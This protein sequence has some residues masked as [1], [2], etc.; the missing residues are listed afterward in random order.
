MPLEKLTGAPISNVWELFEDSNQNIWVGT[1][2]N[3][4]FPDEGW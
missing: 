2:A 1:L 4:V 3:G